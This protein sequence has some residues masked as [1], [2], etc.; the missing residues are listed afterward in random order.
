MDGGY[1]TFEIKKGPS[2]FFPMRNQ[3]GPNLVGDQ[4]KQLAAAFLINCVAV[5]T[6]FS[7]QCVKK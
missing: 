7:F 4:T 5:R 3:F 6:G 1:I 2:V